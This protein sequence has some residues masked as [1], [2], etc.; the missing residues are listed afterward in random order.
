MSSVGPRKKSVRRWNLYWLK[1][2]TFVRSRRDRLV[3][4]AIS[5]N[6]G[7][8]YDLPEV[9]KAYCLTLLCKAR[10]PLCCIFQRSG[11]H[12]AT[13]RSTSSLSFRTQHASL[14]MRPLSH[15]HCHIPSLP[16]FFLNARTYTSPFPT[17][18][19]LACL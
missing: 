5:K 7:L 10:A 14:P 8:C 9:T 19:P 11:V 6:S 12:K 17:S 3:H 15:L 16:M 13:P 1:I 2:D 18:L 4:R